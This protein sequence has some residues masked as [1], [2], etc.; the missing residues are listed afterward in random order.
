MSIVVGGVEVPTLEVTPFDGTTQ[1]TVVVE[2]PDGDET[3][4]NTEGADDTPVEGTQTWTAEAVTYDQPGRWV[5]HWAV[6]GTG[7]GAA[8]HRV[9]V[10]RAM[11]GLPPITVDPTTSIGRVRLLATDL[12][13]VTP[14]FEDAQIQAFLAME[15]NRVRRAA[16][17]ALE[18]IAVS[19]ALISK[20]IRTLDLQ[21]DGT[22]V[23]AELR[24][25]AKSLRDQ[26]DQYDDD[27]NTWGL[28]IVEFDQW[29]AYRTSGV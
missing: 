8:E 12:D 25:R 1:A 24:A 28:E 4:P 19:E 26:E 27:G 13:E 6:V 3:T 29:A 11:V 17:M 5:F 23:A 2:G 10:T 20:V 14:L 7:A 21:T 22:K 16:A 18:T 15:G 9:M